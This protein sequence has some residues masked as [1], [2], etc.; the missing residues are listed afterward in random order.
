MLCGWPL[1][2]FGLAVVLL[3]W[4]SRKTTW[5]HLRITEK[6]GKG[7]RI[8]FPLPLTLA[9]WVLKLVEPFVPQLRNTGV[10]EVIFA[11]RDSARS[12]EPISI[13]VEDDED[14]ERV[15]VYIG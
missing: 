10:D 5:M 14:G 13:D 15:Q 1:F 4:W 3:V 9:A 12:G 8:S 2:L 11:L 7:F 6:K